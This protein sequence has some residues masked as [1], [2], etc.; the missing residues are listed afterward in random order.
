[1]WC[2][3]EIRRMHN[4]TSLAVPME[5]GRLDSN[6]VLSLVQAVQSEVES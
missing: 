6:Q 2:G 1:M 3:I 4:R 5:L